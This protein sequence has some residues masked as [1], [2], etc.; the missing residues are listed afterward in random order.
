MFCSIVTALSIILVHLL[1]KFKFHYLPES[2]AVVGLGV[3]IGLIS[4]LTKNAK[5]AEHDITVSH[6][7]TG[8]LI[9]FW[10]SKV[11]YESTNCVIMN[12]LGKTWQ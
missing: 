6:W 4:L 9:D 11:A 8:T 5:I 3:L 2:I 10:P 7:D 1:I 12:V